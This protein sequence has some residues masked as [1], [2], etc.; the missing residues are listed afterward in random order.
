MERADIQADRVQ[1][2]T[3]LVD[4]RADHIQIRFVSFWRQLVQPIKQ[5]QLACRILAP[6]HQHSEYFELRPGKC[7]RIA[8][9]RYD[10]GGNV[11]VKPGYGKRLS[12]LIANVC[13]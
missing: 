9:E 13:H 7:D 3:H 11:E 8:I 1:L 2:P 6:L 5:V 4:E 10:T 12:A